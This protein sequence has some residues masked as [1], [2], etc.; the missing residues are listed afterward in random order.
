MKLYLKNKLLPHFMLTH[1][2]RN[3][4]LYLLVVFVFLNMYSVLCQQKLNSSNLNI[5]FSSKQLT[6]K[7]VLDELNTYPEINI[8]YSNTREYKKTI[9]EFDSNP[10]NIQ[11]VLSAIELQ[12]PVEIILNNNHTIV[13]LKEL[14]DKYTFSGNIQDAETDEILVGVNVYLKDFYKGTVSDKNGDFVLQ[15]SPGQYIVVIKY[16]GYN[17]QEIRINL[18]N[19]IE[20]KIRLETKHEEIEEVN[21]IG[22][23]GDIESLKTG[24]T[25]ESIESKTIDH[26]S[27][28][29]PNDVL[30]GRVNGV[31][32]TKV[33]GAPGD[34]NKIRIRGIS[35]IFGST[36]PLY[37]VDGMIVPIINFKTL[38][39]ADLNTHDINN[40]TVLKDASSTALYGYLGG[41]GV[42][43]I[44]TKKGGGKTSFEASIKR[45]YQ[46][47]NKRYSLLNSEDFYSTLKTSD[48]LLKT[49]FYTVN[50]QT[51]KYELY[52][53][54][55]DSLGNTLGYDNFQDMLF[56]KGS[57]SEYQLSAQGNI[58]TIDYYISGNYYTHK[59]IIT[60]SKYDKYTVTGNFS[61]IIRDKASVRI[62]YRKSSGEY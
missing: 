8:V 15:L 20:K 37:V 22:K 32:V 49:G 23:A 29:D 18:Y 36:D 46:Q 45:G 30:H 17:E 48:Q 21:I 61:K 31:W 11:K 5:K 4:K 40:I 60:N 16:L 51:G 27:T 43:L 35:S 38:G 62:L 47:F 55:R 10:I 14:K 54:Y 25:I 13:K 57:I 6:L 28:N 42:V 1:K 56:R 19:N 50:T 2:P 34:H 52:P 39:I 12:A 9:I 41:N 33:S 44:E 3:L 7:Q 58:K 26:L 53:V 59:G 24:R